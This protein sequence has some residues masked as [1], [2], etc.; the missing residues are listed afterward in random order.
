MHQDDRFNVG[1]SPQARLWTLVM[2][3]VM[4]ASA[5]Q[6]ARVPSNDQGIRATLRDTV[7]IP[8]D[9]V[10]VGNLIVDRTE[11]RESEVVSYGGCNWSTATYRG[12]V[13]NVRFSDVSYTKIGCM[14]TIPGV[15]LSVFSDAQVYVDDDIMTV[16][17]ARRTTRYRRV[18]CVPGSGFYVGDDC[19]EKAQLVVPIPREFSSS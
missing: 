4:G 2:L 19:S 18:N 7:W 16:Q 12:T 17:N 9:A 14:E 10:R 1:F 5:L 15:G 6:T 13:W 8:V 3:A 11:F